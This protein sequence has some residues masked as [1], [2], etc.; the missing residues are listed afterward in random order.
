MGV[1]KGFAITARTSRENVGPAKE[2]EKQDTEAATRKIVKILD[3]K[4]R[5]NA[6]DVTQQ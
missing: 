5:T 4:Q 3:T 1:E 2:N 6:K